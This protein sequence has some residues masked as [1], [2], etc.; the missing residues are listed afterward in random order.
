MY[1][2]NKNWEFV[3]NFYLFRFNMT[4]CVN[5]QKHKFI[6]SQ[7]TIVT[8]DIHVSTYSKIHSSTVKFVFNLPA[9][10]NVM[11]V[12]MT[13]SIWPLQTASQPFWTECLTTGISGH[14]FHTWTIIH[15][16]SILLFVS[17]YALSRLTNRLYTY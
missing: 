10:K 15:N 6:S 16:R 4:S 14:D 11:L 3:K 5:K 7:N 2:C 1:A 12:K 17:F 9:S 13:I 8:E